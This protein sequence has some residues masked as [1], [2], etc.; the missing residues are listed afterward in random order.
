[1]I[2]PHSEGNAVEVGESAL[3]QYFWF[4][5]SQNEMSTS[6]TQNQTKSV[7]C[8]SCERQLMITYR[9]GALS[10]P[11]SIVRCPF[12]DHENDVE[13][14]GTVVSVVVRDQRKPR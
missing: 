11:P 12:C 4:R 8:A 9:T 3:V 1:V 10:S 7:P 5:P 13:L 6:A 2:V 14:D